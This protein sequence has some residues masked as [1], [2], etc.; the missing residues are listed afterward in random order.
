MVNL[1]IAMQTSKNRK[2]ANKN[3]LMLLTA[4]TSSSLWKEKTQQIIK[5]FTES[6]SLESLQLPLV[7]YIVY[8]VL[9]YSLQI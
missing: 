2:E 6:N 1:Y 8:I 3:F 9:T 4:V 5:L 7:I